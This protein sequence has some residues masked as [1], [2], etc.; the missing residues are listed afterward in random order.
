[1]TFPIC[2]SD[3]VFRCK[4]TMMMKKKRSAV[5]AVTPE[6]RHKRLKR[7]ASVYGCANTD[8]QYDRVG[9]RVVDVEKE[10]GEA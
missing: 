9:Y 5:G 4:N 8:T 2:L 6:H 3:A 7:D 1:M 10:H